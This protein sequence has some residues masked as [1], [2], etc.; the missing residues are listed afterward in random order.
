MSYVQADLFNLSD[1]EILR[2]EIRSLEKTTDNVR[3]GIFVRHE[4]L[5]KKYMEQREEIDRLKDVIYAMQDKMKHYEEALFPVSL[6]SGVRSMSAPVCSFIMDSH[7]SST[8][9][10][11]PRK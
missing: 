8:G 2:G 7:D 3:R 9:L 4:E 11:L 6:T 10:S 5:A 1:F